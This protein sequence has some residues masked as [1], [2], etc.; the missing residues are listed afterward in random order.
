M[1]ELP[2]NAE[3][4]AGC[5]VCQQPAVVS[6]DAEVTLHAQAAPAGRRAYAP[7]PISLCREHADEYHGPA[8]HF[9]ETP[10]WERES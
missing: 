5:I 8:R 1:S 3:S 4:A 10:W 9:T 2:H 7:M 6:V